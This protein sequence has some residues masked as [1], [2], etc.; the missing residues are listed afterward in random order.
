[1][2]KTDCIDNVLKAVLGEVC[3]V[4]RQHPNWPEDVFKQLA[5]IGEE[6]GEAQQAALKAED[7]QGDKRLVEIE[8]E[9]VAAMALRF[10]IEREYKGLALT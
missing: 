5:I 10:L 4:Q 3:R 1:M 8:V 9:Q 7:G 6:F 2:K